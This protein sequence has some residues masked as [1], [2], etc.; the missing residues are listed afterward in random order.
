MKIDLNLMNAFA[1]V[2]RERSVG[3]AAEALNYPSRR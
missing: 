3:R 1:A 2:Y